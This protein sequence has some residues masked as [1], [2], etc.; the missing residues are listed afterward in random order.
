MSRIKNFSRNLTASYLQLVVNM[1][2]SLVSIPLILHWLPQVEFGLWAVLIQLTGYISL[3]DL[4]MTSAVARLLVDHKDQRHTD[5]YGSLIKTAFWVSLSQGGI[6]LFVIETSAPFLA[7]LMK[8]PAGYEQTFTNLIRLQGLV[9]AFG[10]TMRPLAQILYAHQRSD[11]S[12][13]NDM[14]SLVCQLVMLWVFLTM[15]LGVYSF[16]YA[17]A[18]Y[19]LVGPSVLFWHC[20]RLGFF[21]KKNQTG[22]ASWMIFQDM[23][24]YGK[25]VF[26]MGLGYQLTMASQTII[27][28][29]TLGLDVAAAWAVGTKMFNMIIP[30][31]ARPF[32]A[33]LPGLYEMLSRNEMDRLRHRFKDMVV[34]TSSLGALLGVAFALCN[35]LFVHVW[36]TGKIT[37]SPLNDVLLGAWVFVL[38]ITG[39]HANFVTVTK[40]I[41]GM[42]YVFFLE[43][44]CFVLLASIVSAHWGLL[45]VIACS[46]FCTGFFSCLYALHRSRVYFQCSWP[47]LIIG[48][49]LP[50]WQLLLMFAPLAVIVWFTGT[51]LQPLWRLVIN[52]LFTLIVGIGLFL[53]LGLPRGLI[54]DLGNRLPQPAGRILQFFIPCKN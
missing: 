40:Q 33:S 11:L 25:D 12:S 2:Y 1:I 4:G 18:C 38:S 35:S 9:V 17:G 37:W 36:T 39:T 16:I 10:F 27:V 7:V 23:F 20:H 3:I 41:G 6:I 15:G 14:M 51:A 32:G 53:R 22:R 42:R 45:G 28:S 46:L 49:V 5:D 52:S 43:G 24:A 54:L 19:A 50:S 30:L 48:W 29:R 21:P 13:F 8:I 44:C 47:T 34:L 31:M 26:L